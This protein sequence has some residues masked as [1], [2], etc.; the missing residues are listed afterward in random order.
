MIYNMETLFLILAVSILF[1]LALL[2]LV[3]IVSKIVEIIFDTTELF[4]YVG[5]RRLFY[6]VSIISAIVS[7]IVVLISK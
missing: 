6:I 1:A 2:V 4:E 3:Y 5:L 7:P